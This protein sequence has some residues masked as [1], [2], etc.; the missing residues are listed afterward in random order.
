M[1][2]E[3]FLNVAKEK[4]FDGRSFSERHAN[5]IPLIKV[6]KDQSKECTTEEIE[7]LKEIICD[8]SFGYSKNEMLRQFLDKMCNIML[9][10][11]YVQPVDSEH[12]DD[13]WFRSLHDQDPRVLVVD[14]MGEDD[15]KEYFE[16]E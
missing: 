12:P 3:E 13:P 11:H 1:N 2:K 10:V 14:D 9:I 5:I 6:I 15:M 8:E 4:F 16:D 7:K